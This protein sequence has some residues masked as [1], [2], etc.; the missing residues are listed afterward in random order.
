MCLE[1]QLRLSSISRRC[2]HP[3]GKHRSAFSVLAKQWE[4]SECVLDG[5]RIKEGRRARRAR[6]ARHAR[7]YLLGAGPGPGFIPRPGTLTDVPKPRSRTL[8][9]ANCTDCVVRSFFLGG[10]FTGKSLLKKTTPNGRSQLT[11]IA[12]SNQPK[13]TK[14]A[15]PAKTS[16]LLAAPPLQANAKPKIQGDPVPV[17]TQPVLLT[18]KPKGK[19][20]SNHRLVA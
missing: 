20:S 19:W 5:N 4:K 12:T 13:P 17:D 15:K 1:T 16:R 2:R 11:K 3:I 18:H 14:Q 8:H 6:R 10:E 9:T 7:W